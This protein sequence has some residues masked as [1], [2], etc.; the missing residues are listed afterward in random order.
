MANDSN[1][2]NGLFKTKI[3]LIAATLGSAVGL[4]SIWRFPAE[5]QE[6]GGGAFFIVYIFCILLLGIP[7]MVAEMA[8]GRSGGFGLRKKTDA[9]RLTAT[10]PG[11][12]AIDEAKAGKWRYA[13]WL[14]VLASYM[15]L[16]FYMVVAGWTFEYLWDSITNALYSDIPHSLDGIESAFQLRMERYIASDWNPL[17]STWIVITMNIGILMLGVQKGIER[18]SNIMMPL[19]FVLLLVFGCYALTLPGA[20]EGLDFFFRP[21]FSKITWPMVG[22]ALGQTFFSLSLGTGILATYAAYYPSDTRLPQTSVTVSSLTTLVA[23][24]MGIIIFPAVF[25]F[26]LDVNSLRGTTL[27]FVT[28]PE[29]FAEMPGTQWIS[30]LFFT[31]LLVAALTSTISIAEV[32]VAFI[33]KNFRKKRLAATFIALTPL[34]I[35]SSLCALSFGRLSDVK[36]FGYTIFNFLD[37]FTTNYMLPI[38][39]L[40]G[41]VYIGWFAPHDTLRRQITNDGTVNR[42]LWRLLSFIIR[43]PAP[44][45]IIVILISGLLK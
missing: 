11:A 14:G 30:I 35:L 26:G 24:M 41:V 3:G 33:Q 16:C 15:I 38:T 34:T 8:I 21:D 42:R 6:N 9:G 12:V 40:A 20:K 37:T 32:S 18:A 4:G 28:L 31:L 44:L 39:A 22:N 45:L 7:V 19:L 13:A 36:I 23:V 43:Y 25:T 1:A 29:V 10:P 2:A 27:V 5:A 17:I